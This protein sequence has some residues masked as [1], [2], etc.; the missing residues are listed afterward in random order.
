M[1]KGKAQAMNS[2]AAPHVRKSMFHVAGDSPCSRL[3]RSTH[4]H[5]RTQA[6]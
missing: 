2:P 4:Q 5:V 6:K 1:N 3:S